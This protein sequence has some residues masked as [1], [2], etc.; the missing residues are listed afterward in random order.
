M[1]PIIFTVYVA[2]AST[3]SRLALENLRKV[4]GKYFNGSS[5]IEI[6]DALAEPVRAFEAGVVATPTVVREWPEPRLVL[7]GNLTD[8]ARL[9]AALGLN[10]KTP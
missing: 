5:Q 6:V 7:V 9:T 1:K 8:E 3:N 10:G 4:C 2:G